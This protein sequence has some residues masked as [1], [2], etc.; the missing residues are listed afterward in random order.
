MKLKKQERY[1]Y[2]QG[3]YCVSTFQPHGRPVFVIHPSISRSSAAPL[4]GYTRALQSRAKQ[5][6]DS[7]SEDGGSNLFR[8]AKVRIAMGTS[9]AL[10][11]YELGIFNE[12]FVIIKVAGEVAHIFHVA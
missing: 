5:I 11:A 1:F 3:L 8:F 7:P 6:C 2:R 9:S 10:F 12:L 4:V